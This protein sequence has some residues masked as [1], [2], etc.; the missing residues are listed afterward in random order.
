MASTDRDYF[1]DAREDE[2]LERRNI[3]FW[4]ALADHISNDELIQKNGAILDIGCHRGGLL[5]LLANRFFPSR[6]FGI[7]PVETARNIA[8]RRFESKTYSSKFYSDKG[9]KEVPDASINLVVCHE[10]LQYLPD[11]GPII[12]ETR[13]VLT[14]KGFALFVL[15]CHTENPLWSSWK[16]DMIK[17]GHRLY[18]HAP[19]DILAAGAKIGLAP[20]LRPLRSD[21]WIFHNP[22]VSGSFRYPSAHA[23]LDHQF[24]HKLLFRFEKVP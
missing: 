4:E 3:H 2:E 10:V 1:F 13:R 8:R 11:L 18:D 12:R 15:G 20:A 9:L 7:E 5:E 16:T 17:T 23:L 22:T 6:I 24:K 14:S 21:G 19:L